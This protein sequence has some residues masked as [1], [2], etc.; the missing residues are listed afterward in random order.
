MAIE[1]IIPRRLA[2]WLY[3]VSLLAILCGAILS[4]VSYLQ[5]CVE[6]CAESHNWLL[7]GFPFEYTGLFFFIPLLFIHILSKKYPPLSFVAGLMIASGIGAEIKFILVQKF[8][9]GVWCPLCLSIAACIFVAG[10]CYAIHYL[11]E[12]NTLIKQGPRGELMKTIWKGI[13]GI[14]IFVLGFLIATIGISKFDQIAAQE[15]TIKESLFFGDKTSPIEVYLFTDWACPACRQLEPEIEKMAPEVMKQ[16][17][18][19]FVDHAI[20]TETLNYSP[21]NVSFMIKNKP[22]YFKLRGELTKMSVATEAP[23]DQEIEK[24][25]KKVGT[26]Y[27]QLN[28]SDIAISQKYFKQLAKQFS[29]TKTPVMVVVNIKTKKGKK[30]TGI[31]EI[32]ESNVLKAIASLKKQPSESKATSDKGEDKADSEKDEDKE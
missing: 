4:L 20:H 16:A 32:T 24:I 6:E 22:D 30:L 27:Q 15:T 12:M 5:I 7:F 28:F 13:T 25:A 17:K 10:V 2:D 11:I 23:T 3:L 18:L 1:K 14:S 26:T 9:I 31:A 8:Q 19:T 29:I 21:Y